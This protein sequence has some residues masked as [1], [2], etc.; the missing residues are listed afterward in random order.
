M[1]AASMSR[2]TMRA[3]LGIIVFQGHIKKDVFF[4]F[5]LC[6][7]RCRIRIRSPFHS[8]ATIF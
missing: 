2:W 7:F 8:V 3:Y 1:S 6:I 5:I 4:Y